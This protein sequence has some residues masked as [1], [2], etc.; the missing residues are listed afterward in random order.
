[1]KLAQRHLLGAMALLTT[2]LVQSA[3]GYELRTHATVTGQ[4]FDASQG[5][6]L[7]LQDVAADSVTIFAPDAVTR[8]E[9]LARFENKGTARGWIAEGTERLPFLAFIYICQK[10]SKPSFRDV[11]TKERAYR[12]DKTSVTHHGQVKASYE[13]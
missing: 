9:Q 2:L 7:Y 10:C 4:S 3:G 1:M 6:R 12:S 13:I 11:D 5:I 8:F